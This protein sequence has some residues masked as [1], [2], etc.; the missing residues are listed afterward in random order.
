MLAD[1]IRTEILF[2]DFVPVNIFSVIRSVQS[3][4]LPIILVRV[5]GSI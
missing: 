5:S 2:F 1:V 3:A 4:N